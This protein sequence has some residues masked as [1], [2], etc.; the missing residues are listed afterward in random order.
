MTGILRKILTILGIFSAGEIHYI[1]GSDVLPPPLKTEQ[2]SDA[3][4]AME[5]GDEAAKKL[6]I[7]RNLRLVVFIAKRF[8]S[9]IGKLLYSI[10]ESAIT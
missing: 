5:Q 2:E 7:E 1:G 3:L 4:E 6:L 10:V 9:F 8:E